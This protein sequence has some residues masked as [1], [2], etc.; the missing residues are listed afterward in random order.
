[1][2]LP[3]LKKYYDQIESGE[4]EYE[5]RD[6]H[7]TFICEETGRTM[8]RKVIHTKVVDKSVCCLDDP[9]MFDDDDL[10]VFV[11]EDRK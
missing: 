7:I 6:A 4:K 3:I 9:D 10:I 8:T 1:M 2:K 11:L 5:F